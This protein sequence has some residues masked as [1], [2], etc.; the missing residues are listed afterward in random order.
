MIPSTAEFKRNF[1]VP[2]YCKCGCGKE[3]VTKYN[4]TKPNVFYN[5]L[6]Y[7]LYRKRLFQMKK[8]NIQLETT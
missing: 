7:I 2:T 4:R 5:R 3:V 8:G 6:C 1:Y